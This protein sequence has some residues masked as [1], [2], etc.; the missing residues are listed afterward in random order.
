VET[1]FFVSMN[2]HDLKIFTRKFLQKNIK[3][4][5]EKNKKQ[6]HKK[7]KIIFYK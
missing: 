1:K 2:N 5:F 6:Y 4:S 3:K 7:N